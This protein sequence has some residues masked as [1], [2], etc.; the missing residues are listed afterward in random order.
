[1][2]GGDEGREAEDGFYE[3]REHGCDEGYECE[4]GEWAD[5]EEEEQWETEQSAQNE[6]VEACN[7]DIS[8]CEGRVGASD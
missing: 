6:Q 5:S 4:A 3:E 2:C 7:W 1:M 8:G